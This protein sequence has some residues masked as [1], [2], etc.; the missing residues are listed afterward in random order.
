[1]EHL[2]HTHR[3]VLRRCRT[4]QV[5]RECTSPSLERDAWANGTGCTRCSRCFPSRGPPEPRTPA[6]TPPTSGLPRSRASGRP[7]RAIRPVRVTRA[8]SGPTRTGARRLTRTGSRTEP[9]GGRGLGTGEGAEGL[10]TL[11]VE[12]DGR[13]VGCVGAGLD[14]TNQLA[15]VGYWTAPEARRQGITTTARRPPSSM[16]RGGYE[17]FWAV[18]V[19]RGTS[20]T[21]PLRRCSLLV[22]TCRDLRGCGLA[23]PRGLPSVCSAERPHVAQMLPSGSLQGDRVWD[24]RHSRGGRVGGEASSRS[25]WGAS[26]SPVRRSW[27]RR[28]TAC[29]SA[30]SFGTRP[31]TCRTLSR[32]SGA[33]RAQNVHAGPPL[34]SL[35]NNRRLARAN[36]FSWD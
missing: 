11:L 27:V 6:T 1:M 22:E 24:Q 7:A 21:H 4:Q 3:A 32:P 36:E 17:P 31:G 10:Q 33:T 20:G 30:A 35:E 26:P 34:V 12:T 28:P 9:L 15:V 2:L 16:I 14:P 13:V 29:G 23:D 5:R 8:A 25:L 19:S 18:R